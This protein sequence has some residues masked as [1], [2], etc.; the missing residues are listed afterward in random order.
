MLIPSISIKRPLAATVLAIVAAPLMLA[1]SCTAWTSEELPQ[2]MDGD[3]GLGDYYTHSIIRGDSDKLNVLPYLDFDYG[4]L[5]ARVDTLGVKTLKMGYGY[6]ELVGRISQDGF[7]TNASGLQGL[8][9]RQT[10][11]PVGIGTFQVTPI[12]AFMVNAFH[13]VNQSQGNMLEAIYG[14]ELDLPRVIL[15]PLI[16]AE[17]QSREYVSYYYGVSTQEA[18]SSKYAAYQP[19]GSYNSLIGLIADISLTDEYHLNFCVRHKWLGDSIQL[20]PIVNQRYLDTG[21]L[22]LSYRF[23]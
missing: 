11:I 17:Y 15:Y 18:A 8:H 23:K 7:S 4:K 20:S 9:T 10:S 1:F 21:Y 5:F 13:D 6:L 16:G 19:A 3:V 22:S 14:V 2:K 12:G